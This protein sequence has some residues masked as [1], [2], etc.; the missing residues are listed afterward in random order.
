MLL[1]FKLLDEKGSDQ[2]YNKVYEKDGFKVFSDGTWLGTKQ[3]VFI[4]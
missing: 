4:H 2:R 3:I 1:V